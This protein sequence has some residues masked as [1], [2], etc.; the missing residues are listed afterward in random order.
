MGL[1]LHIGLGGTRIAKLIN[2]ESCLREGNVELNLCLSCESP[3][4]VVN[5]GT[6]RQGQTAL[7]S[8]IVSLQIITSYVMDGSPL[9]REQNPPAGGLNYEASYSNY[10]V[11]EL[12]YPVLPRVRRGNENDRT[13]G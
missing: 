3:L 1:L 4:G 5:V 13:L 11:G 9:R 10:G 2:D 7:R 8:G 12:N 6:T